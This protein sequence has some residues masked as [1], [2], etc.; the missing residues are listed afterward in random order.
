[1]LIETAVVGTGDLRVGIKA[2]N[3]TVT[4][5]GRL[6]VKRLLSLHGDFTMVGESS[7]VEVDAG[8]V[9]DVDR[10]TSQSCPQ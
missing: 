3:S 4:G 7:K 2:D 5:H 10:F 8:V 6:Q 9:F 1:M